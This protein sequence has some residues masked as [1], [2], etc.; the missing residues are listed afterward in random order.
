[1]LVPG[2]AVSDLADVPFPNL[3]GVP[4]MPGPDAD[5]GGGMF[6]VVPVLIGV[7]FLV[8]VVLAV[9]R[10]VTAGRTHAANAASPEQTVV[11]RVVAK[12]TRTE[13]GGND[14]A[15]RTT[16]FVTFERPDGERVELTVPAREYGQLV[17]GDEGRLTHQGTWYRGFERNRMP[18]L[19]GT[20][21]APAGP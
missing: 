5:P 11:A 20:W 19:D 13:G 9:A 17:E 4:G 21:E 2:L 7:V 8:V 10:L 14:T 1:M 12:R 16:S 15:V 18:R 3:P 6:T